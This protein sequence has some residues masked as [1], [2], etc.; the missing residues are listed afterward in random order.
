MSDTGDTDDE[1]EIVRS[2]VIL[3]ADSDVTFSDP[4]DVIRPT[5]IHH[6]LDE[7]PAPD[8]LTQRYNYYVYHFERDGFVYQARA[9]VEFIDEVSILAPLDQRQTD[10]GPKAEAFRHD[11]LEYLKRR[12]DK[13]DEL[14]EN[15]Y[16]TIWSRPR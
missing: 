15:G 2:Q 3:G 4:L 9:Y 11:V 7:L 13:I 1:P 10:G 16:V 5:S 6:H 14:G 12:F 8:E